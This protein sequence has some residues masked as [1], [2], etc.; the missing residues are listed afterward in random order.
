MTQEDPK[1]TSS[2]RHTK[3][4]AKEGTISSEKYLQAGW[5][6]TTHWAKEKKTTS[7]RV[8]EAGIQSCHKTH[9]WNSDPKLG[10]NSKARPLL[11]EWRVWPHTRHPNFKDL[12]LSNKLPKYLALQINWAHNND[13][14][15]SVLFWETAQ[16]GLLCWD[17]PAPGQPMELRL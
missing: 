8:G 9:P 16:K 15:K 3:S 5:T 12:H 17:S 11:E 13:I 4:T 1:L 7:K 2:Y 14:H 6:I 10:G